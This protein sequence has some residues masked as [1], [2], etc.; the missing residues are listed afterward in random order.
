MS[1]TN[2]VADLD[3]WIQGPSNRPFWLLSE[4]DGY[5]VYL[6]ALNSNLTTKL[7]CRDEAQR[8]SGRVVPP[9]RSRRACPAACGG[10]ALSGFGFF[11]HSYD[12][13]SLFVSSIDIPV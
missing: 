6:M 7:T 13:I 10:N 3:V 12:Y 1:N 2:T 5:I 4:L 8:N 11:C 9:E